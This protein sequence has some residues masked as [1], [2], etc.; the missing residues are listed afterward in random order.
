MN[1]DE[2]L[3]SIA[4]T[5]IRGLGSTSSLRLIRELGSAVNVF[6]K[7]KDI[8]DLIPDVND[9][10]PQLLD[11]KEAMSKA[12]TEYDFVKKNNLHC[13]TYNDENYPSRLRE[14]EDAPILL[15]CQ[16]DA[17]LN[18]LHM[19]SMV[20]TRHCTDYGKT[21]CN[22]F[23]NELC[24]LLPNVI[25]VSGLAYGIDISS[26]RAALANNMRTIA[27]LAHGLDRIYPYM[28]RD[29]AKEMCETGGG[30][31]TEFTTGTNP[32]RQNFVMRNRIVAGMCDATIVVESA[33]KGGSLIT[34]DLATGYGRDC[35]AFPGPIDAEY[36][37]G[38]NNLI[39]DNKAGLISC[40]E[41]FVKAMGWTRD[42]SLVKDAVQREL[43]VELSTDEKFVVDTL[44]KE[45]KS[46]INTLVVH[47]NI[48]VNKLSSILFELE[49]KG[50]VRSLA[51][52]MYELL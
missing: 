8:K 11:D 49:L 14:C 39:R 13:Y 19:I 25:V 7:R 23:L 3:A 22:K 6:A 37:K 45:G 52:S 32:D 20:G 24:E 41:D 21:I 28:H 42:K 1:E 9:R 10:I 33:T 12:M 50:V 26:H 35:F 47:T 29:T 46:Q 2:I 44:R 15:F 27:V 36:S 43:F 34:A 40:A 18:E 31:V 51:G 17:N 5:K 38:C 16:G 30:L 4:L 48:A